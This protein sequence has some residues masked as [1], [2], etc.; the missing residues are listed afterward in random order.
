VSSDVDAL[1]GLAPL[2]V[3]QRVRVRLG[4]ECPVHSRPDLAFMDGAIGVVVPDPAEQTGPRHP[5]FVEF[6]PWIRVEGDMAAP[7][8]GAALCS[9]EL[10]RL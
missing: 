10:E 4:G 6:T 7:Y 8:S 5:L 2:E 1:L 3:G 9:A